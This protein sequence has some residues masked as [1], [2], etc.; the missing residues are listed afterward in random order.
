MIHDT[1]RD[2]TQKGCFGN[3]HPFCLLEKRRHFVYDEEV[4]KRRYMK[5]HAKK[6]PNKQQRPERIKQLE[7]HLGNASRFL[8]MV[9]RRLKKNV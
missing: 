1:N 8:E 6:S 7:R 3:E 9:G 4:V 5:K 2:S